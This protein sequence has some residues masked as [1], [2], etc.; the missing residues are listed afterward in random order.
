MGLFLQEEFSITEDL[1]LSAGIRRDTARYRG[2]DGAQ[3]GRNFREH[4]EEWSPKAALTY[5]VFEPVS[6][7]VSYARGFRFPNIDETFGFFGFNP[8]LVPQTSDA[9]EGGVKIR[10]K[11]IA[12]NLTYFNMDVED[13]I[14]LLVIP[15]LF[16]QNVNLDRV[17]HQGVE[18]SGNV[19]PFEWLEIFGS[20]TY[21][22]VRI[23]RVFES[24]V[25]KGARMPITPEHRGNVGFTVFLPWG[26]EI[27]GN[28]N[29]VGSRFVANDVVEL[30]DK[31]PR[32]ATYDARIGWRYALPHGF[33]VRAEA[34]A[35]N[36][37]NREYNEFGAVSTFPP[38]PLGFFP[39]PGRNYLASLWLEYRL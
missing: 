26:F 8:G 30:V 13:E 2:E 23:Q 16:A 24:S 31:L 39:S 9:L 10:T 14:Y 6:V 19:R 29:Y 36:L 7:Y 32:F 18:I 17:R 35:Y 38:F 11:R 20:Y 28:A 27:G 3:P 5:R 12:L 25:L 15:N 22:N 21:D 37:T 33:T 4:F 1:I 34:S